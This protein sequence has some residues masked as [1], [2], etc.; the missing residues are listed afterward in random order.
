M[1]LLF[2]FFFLADW[3]EEL[4]R[5]PATSEASRAQGRWRPGQA[6][7]EAAGGEERVDGGERGRGG[8]AR[9][10]MRPG[11]TREEGSRDAR[12]MPTM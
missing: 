7:Q 11:V 9:A 2:F 3:Y 10:G 1:N 6:A 12:G 4:G 8:P 5:E